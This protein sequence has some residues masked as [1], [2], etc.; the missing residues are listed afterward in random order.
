MPYYRHKQTLFEVHP[1]EV[2]F[3]VQNS[4]VSIEVHCLFEACSTSEQ[5][6]HVSR[7]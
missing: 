7:L 3:T 2:Q 6:I 4:S 1:T 5:H